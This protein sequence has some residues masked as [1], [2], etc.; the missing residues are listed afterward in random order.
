M[1]KAITSLNVEIVK[2]SDQAK[3]IVVL[4]KR[5]VVER[6]FA[7]FNRC[8][9]LAKDWECLNAKA[10]AFLKHDSIRIMLRRLCNPNWSPQ[11]DSQSLWD[12]KA[13]KSAPLT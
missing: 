8:R 5:W 1:E 13:Y 7:W 3:G 6:S 12:F 4:P 10:F 2:C 9:R 11:T